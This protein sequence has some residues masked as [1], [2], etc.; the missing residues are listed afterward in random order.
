MSEFSFPWP[1]TDPQIGDGRAYTDEEWNQWDEAV[2]AAMA[3]EGGY[4][5][6]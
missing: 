3:S 4:V 2:I 1:K 6:I 5:G